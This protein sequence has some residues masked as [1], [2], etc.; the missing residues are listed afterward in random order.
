MQVDYLMHMGDDRFVANCARVSFDKWHDEFQDKDEG[1]IRFLAING[2]WSPFAHPQV[3]F[4]VKAPLFVA[5]Q[6]AKHQ[7]GAAWNEVSRRY[8]TYKPE[9]YE[10]REWRLAAPNKKQGSSTETINLDKITYETDPLIT[11]QE[12]IWDI[13][14]W[15]LDMYNDMIK[16]G[17][18][19]EQARMILPQ[20]M[21]TT[22]IW[23]GSLLFFARVCTLRLKS[24]TQAET[25]QV[26]QM[27]DVKMSELFPVSWSALKGFA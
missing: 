4:R 25:R 3:S 26:A 11:Y 13:Q 9:F 16:A 22:W 7:V 14:D 18:C 15:A 1:L 23:T 20:N 5:R 21:Y 19:P 12:R 2:H 17:V 6:L 24:D 10:P 27:I 8:V